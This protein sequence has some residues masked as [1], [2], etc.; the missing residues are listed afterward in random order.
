MNNVYKH[1]TLDSCNR[2]LLPSRSPASVAKSSCVHLDLDEPNS[3]A[4]NAV[5]I[6]LANGRNAS[7]REKR[8]SH[9][10]SHENGW[11]WRK[12]HGNANGGCHG[13]Y[14]GIEKRHGIFQHID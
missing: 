3:T 6:V 13:N 1:G 12:C 2:R 14:S 11:G 7:D 5:L 9:S 8:T 10:A 4:L